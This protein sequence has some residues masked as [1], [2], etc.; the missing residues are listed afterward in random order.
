LIVNQKAFKA[1][2]NVHNYQPVKMPL[3][4]KFIKDKAK[5]KGFF[6]TSQDLN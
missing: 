4:K 2:F 5:L 1:K 3:I 6:Y